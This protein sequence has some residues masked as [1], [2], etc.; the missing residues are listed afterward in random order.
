MNINAGTLYRGL[1]DFARSLNIYLAFPVSLLDPEDALE[2]E[3]LQG[4]V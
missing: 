4:R 3:T 1:D 2:A